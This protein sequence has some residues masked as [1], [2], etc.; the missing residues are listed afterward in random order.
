[1]R[2]L[3]WLLPDRKQDQLWTEEL[4]KAFGDLINGA[5]STPTP[6][7]AHEISFAA[8][9]TDDVAD[10]DRVAHEKDR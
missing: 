10:A 6:A 7:G 5:L 2:R 1:L 8:F 4:A 9:D 3:Q